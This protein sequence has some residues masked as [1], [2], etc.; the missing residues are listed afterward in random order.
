MIKDVQLYNDDCLWIMDSIPD[1]SIDLIL[2]DL[3]YGT[4][5]NKWD[6]MLPLEKLWEQYMRISKGAI[7]LHAAQP[8]TSLLVSSN[9]KHFKYDWIWEKTKATGHLN[10][11]K[12]PLRNK[13]DILVF[14]KKQ[15]TY[16]PQMT[17]GEPYKNKAG[18]DHSSQSSMTGSY[19]K[20]SN[21]RPDNEGTRY[22]KQILKFNVVQRGTLHPTEKPVA[23]LEYL[24]KTYTNP[25][26]LVLDNCMGSGSTGEAALRTGRKF[27]GIEKDK[28]FFDIASNRILNLINH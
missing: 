1:H 17:Q 5:Q 26:D 23:L 14:Y 11:K 10:A 15:P 25:G 8:F 20:Y 3:P 21:Y 18:K 7:V 19:G 9:L 4:T 28:D 12:Q 24:I 27:I 2:C 13:E 22:P 16:N 6:I